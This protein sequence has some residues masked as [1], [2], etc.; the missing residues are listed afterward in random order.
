MRVSEL[1]HEVILNVRM[2]LIK[3]F[4]ESSKN[5]LVNLKFAAFWKKQEALLAFLE[6]V[7]NIELKCEFMVDNCVMILV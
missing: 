1:N 2:D 7:L 3:H 6:N 4:A 5:G